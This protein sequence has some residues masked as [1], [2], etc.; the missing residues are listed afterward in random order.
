MAP[1]RQPND[2]FLTKVQFPLYSVQ[3]IT[4]RHVMVA[5][6]GGSAKTGV[7]NGFVRQNI[8]L[9]FKIEYIFY[10]INL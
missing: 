6:G 5:G 2:G 9:K 7:T 4:S 1:I 8:I 10:P 3:M